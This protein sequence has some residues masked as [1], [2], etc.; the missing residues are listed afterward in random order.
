MHSFQSESESDEDCLIVESEPG[1]VAITPDQRVVVVSADVFVSEVLGVAGRAE[2]RV[3]RA[4]PPIGG[5]VVLYA[6]CAAAAP[7]DPNAWADLLVDRTGDQA[8]A[9]PIT[10]IAALSNQDMWTRAMDVPALAQ[11]VA[12]T[13]LG[14]SADI[15]E[16]IANADTRWKNRGT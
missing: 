5:P 12:G 11:A 7:G 14:A 15:S 6:R 1:F 16:A 3:L 10:G 2:V 9:A 13:D 4:I 8:N